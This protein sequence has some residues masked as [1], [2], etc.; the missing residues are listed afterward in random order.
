MNILSKELPA[1]K[2]RPGKASTRMTCESSPSQPTKYQKQPGP[3]TLGCEIF[4]KNIHIFESAR[5]P[6]SH[7]CCPKCLQ[8]LFQ[9]SLFGN[10]QFPLQCCDEPIIF[11]H[12]ARFLTPDLAKS[13]LAQKAQFEVGDRT[14]CS[15]PF[16]SRVIPPKNIK[17]QGC[18]VSILQ[19]SHPYNLQ[20][21]YSR[22]RLP[23]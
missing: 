9:E 1:L 11:E 15:S 23:G 3:E 4:C 7:I 14:C 13:F 2:I 16:C 18:F 5:L 6:C 22:R 12:V 8:K 19:Y 21:V 10:A 17:R 20:I